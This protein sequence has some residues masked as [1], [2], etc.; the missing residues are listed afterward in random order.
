MSTIHFSIPPPHVYEVLE[1]HL[2]MYPASEILYHLIFLHFSHFVYP[3]I[4]VCM[5]YCELIISARKVMSYIH[6]HGIAKKICPSRLLY[7][8]AT[9]FATISAC[10]GSDQ[11]TCWGLQ[12]C[13]ENIKSLFSPWKP[14]PRR[15]EN[16]RIGACHT[17]DNSDLVLSSR[18]EHDV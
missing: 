5:A 14:C 3:C 8:R 7:T 4:H 6:N 1:H 13:V 11:A 15:I 2:W 16:G 10:S 18:T 9:Y 17:T 12:T